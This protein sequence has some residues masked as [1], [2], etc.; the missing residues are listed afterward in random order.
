[1]D[2]IVVV[3]GRGFLVYLHMSMLSLLST[4][5]NYVNFL[6]TFRGKMYF[7][8]LLQMDL[9]NFFLQQLAVAY[10][11]QSLPPP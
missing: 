3:N 8:P 11:L 9:V 1:M 2:F 6:L 4:G 10:T 5:E 7:L